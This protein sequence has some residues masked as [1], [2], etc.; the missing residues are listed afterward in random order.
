MLSDSL[1]VTTVAVSDLDRARQFFGEQLG[2]PLLDET[3][4]SLRFGAGRGSQVGVR[5]GKP[6]V[7]QT[8]G[9]FEVDDIE[10]T[11]RELTA[12]GVAFEEY[13]TPKTVNYIA[14]IGAARG[15]WFSDPDG[16][17]FGVREG[18]VPA[19]R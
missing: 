9:H 15:A 16:N 17:V 14:Q 19:A 8:V 2:L 3:P 1:L 11:V 13:E 12:R 6:N 7:G 10:A 4:V 18:P 5:R